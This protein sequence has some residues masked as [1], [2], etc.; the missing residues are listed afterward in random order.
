[1]VKWSDQRGVTYLMLMFSIIIIGLAVSVAARQWKTVVQREL[2]ADLLVHG[3]EIQRAIELYSQTKKKGRVVPGE[4]YPLSLEELTTTP[5]P[6]LRKAY[7]DPIG[8]GEWDYVRGP[9]G[10]IKGVRS[11]STAAPIKQSGFPPDVRHFEGLQSYQQWLFTFPNPSTPG[12]QAIQPPQPGTPQGE[13][14][15]GA[16]GM[17]VQ[18]P[19]GLSGIGSM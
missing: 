14:G 17:S 15:S 7:R 18:P 9:K 8:R 5:K 3:I 1:M 13:Q 4:I 10:R 11:P 6:F 12:Q 16:P 2:E 19:A